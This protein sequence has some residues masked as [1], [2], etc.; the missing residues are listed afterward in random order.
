MNTDSE[1]ITLFETKLRPRIAEMSPLVKAGQRRGT[2]GK[3]L[4]LIVLVIF[5]HL[6][7]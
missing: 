7:F 6:A 5:W 2:I 3:C 4:I 1:L